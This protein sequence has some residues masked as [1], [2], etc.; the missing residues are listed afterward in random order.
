V[1]VVFENSTIADAV[2][3]AA[4]V[5]P[6][7]GSAYDKAA[8]ILMTL[9]EDNKRVEIRSTNL[10]ISYL[11]LVNALEV[12]G[13]GSW[14][15]PTLIINGILGKLPIGSG[16]E[17]TLFDSQGAVKL[18]SN[19]T[20]ATIRTGSEWAGYYP[21]WEPFDPEMLDVVEDLG[22]RIKQ[23]EWAAGGDPPMAGIHLNGEMIV[24]TDRYRIATVPCPAEPI[25]KP[26]TVPAGIF[27]PIMKSMRDVAVGIEENQFLL[28]PEPMTQIRANI[29][30]DKYPAVER[31]FLRDHPHSVS[32]KKEELIAMVD[33]AMVFAGNDR[34]PLL[35]MFL[36]KEEIAVMM[37]D[38]EQGLLGDIV[39]VPGQCYHS[40]VK[41]LFTPHNLTD[42]LE[43]APSEQVEMHYETDKH[44]SVRIDGGSGYEAWV[45]PRRAGEA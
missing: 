22:A 11:E 29:Y 41:I 10:L 32:F 6:T 13:T 31:A 28:M 42:A 21:T 17:V 36:G 35:T 1:K 16:K 24:A 12:E 20:A 34:V 14:R 18:Q 26:I 44:K 27:D 9:D 25:Y 7:K 2:S 30:A 15:F 5:A 40:R 37:T 45:M 38:Q 33:R 4:R 23:V 19:R 3:K 8:G 43:A 39:D